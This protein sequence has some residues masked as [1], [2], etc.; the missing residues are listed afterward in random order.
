MSLLVFPL[1]EH[2]G[3]ILYE[4]HAFWND[5][6]CV[7]ELHVA[8]NL[9]YKKITSRHVDRLYGSTKSLMIGKGGKRC[10][11][12]LF[13]VRGC[14]ERKFPKKKNATSHKCFWWFFFLAKS[15]SKTFSFSFLF[16]VFKLRC[17][18]EL[19]LLART[20]LVITLRN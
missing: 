19:K 7:S 12:I 2:I 3:N 10:A 9:N 11:M 15:S 1:K 8:K 6:G 14:D 13:H 17:F 5:S 16:P 4:N 18:R 20:T